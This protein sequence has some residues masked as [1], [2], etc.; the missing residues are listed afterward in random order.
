M[1]STWRNA[2]GLVCLGTCV[3]FAF[4][5]GAGTVGAADAKDVLQ[6]VALTGPGGGDVTITVPAAAGGADVEAFEHVHIRLI[7]PEGSA[8]QSNRS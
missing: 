7:A 2:V 4:A 5:A 6:L 8:E 1:H 3:V